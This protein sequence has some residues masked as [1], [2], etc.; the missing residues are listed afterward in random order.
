[1]KIKLIGM[2]TVFVLMNIGFAGDVQGKIIFEGSPENIV[3]EKNSF[4]GKYLKRY[5]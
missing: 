5:L 4:T 2:L 1:M 3:K